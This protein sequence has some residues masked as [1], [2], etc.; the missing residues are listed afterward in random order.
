MRYA[1]ICVWIAKN[2]LGDAGIISNIMFNPIEPS[3]NGASVMD[4]IYSSNGYGT[5]LVN[6]NSQDFMINCGPA[7]VYWS[8]FFSS[9]TGYIKVIYRV[10]DSEI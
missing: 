5:W 1:A 6:A 8:D 2:L 10:A 3:F 4:N 7:A 9:P